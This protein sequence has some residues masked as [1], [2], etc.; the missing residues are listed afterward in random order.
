[1]NVYDETNLSLVFPSHI[2][3]LTIEF[4]KYSVYI[5]Y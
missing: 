4:N 1:M 3:S 5:I 2:F